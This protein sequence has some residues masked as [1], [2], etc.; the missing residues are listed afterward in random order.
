[1]VGFCDFGFTRKLRFWGGVQIS[2]SRVGH[3]EEKS[4]RWRSYIR[5]WNDVHCRVQEGTKWVRS[6]V[7][8]LKEIW[9]LTCVWGIKLKYWPFQWF[10]WTWQQVV[11]NVVGYWGLNPAIFISTTYTRNICVKWTIGI[12]FFDRGTVGL[13]VCGCFYWWK[14][15]APIEI[16]RWTP[17]NLQISIDFSR[18]LVHVLSIDC[19]GPRGEPFEVFPMYKACNINSNRGC[20]QSLGGWG[21]IWSFFWLE[22]PS[23]PLQN[24]RRTTCVSSHCG[25]MQQTSQIQSQEWILSLTKRR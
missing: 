14:N 17:A 11:R 22:D 21:S 7:R 1:M 25:L 19:L 15:R 3:G 18:R 2:A 13:L 12:S 8:D 9:R 5:A 24:F 6:E 16:Y 10:F 4:C 20:I 23:N